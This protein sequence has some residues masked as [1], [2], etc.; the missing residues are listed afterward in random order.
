MHTVPVR[1]TGP[2]PRTPRGRVRVPAVAALLLAGAAA[3]AGCAAEGGARD[4]GPAPSLSAPPSASPLWPEHTPPTEDER[5]RVTEPYAPVKATVP[6]GGLREM[7]VRDLI[8]RDPNVPGRFAAG[9]KR[10]PG[11]PCGLREPVHRDLTG[12]GEDELLVALDEPDSGLTL[13][14]VY[15]AD[16]RTVQPVLVS[17]GVSGMT[18]AVIGRDLVITGLSVGAGPGTEGR[19]T[20]R[21][22]WNGTQMRPVP[23]ETGQR[24]APDGDI[25]SVVP[26]P[27]AS[28]A[29]PE[30]SPAP[31][32]ASPAP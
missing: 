18:S 8:L 1:T 29:P 21:Y 17:W 32:G 12:D 7:E 22:R 10:C 19:V 2:A 31:R 11:Q 25:D 27:E 14:E 16:G 9:L 28:P 24:G 13:I 4:G 23:P 5:E 15:R 20:T 6:A 3:A 26:V 30:T